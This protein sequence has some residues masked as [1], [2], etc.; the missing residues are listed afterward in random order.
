LAFLA[1]GATI[2]P[3]IRTLF[4]EGKEDTSK[5]PGDISGKRARYWKEFLAARVAGGDVDDDSDVNLW[6]FRL[7]KNTV[8]RVSGL[9]GRWLLA[10]KAGL[11]SYICCSSSSRLVN[12]V[13]TLVSC[14][15]HSST[16]RE[17]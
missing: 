4:S 3:N 7:L 12:I 6:A 13:Q 5:K 2:Q 16:I 17:A 8:R 9:A 15:K 11:F 10:C 14:A 1:S